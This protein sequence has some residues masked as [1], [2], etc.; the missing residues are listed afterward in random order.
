[1]MITSPQNH[2]AIP[3]DTPVTL[4]ANVRPTGQ[5]PVRVTWRTTTGTLGTGNPLTTQLTPAD[6]TVTA[7]AA[8]AVTGLT[9]QATVTIHVGPE[10][11]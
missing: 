7:I 8:D 2:Q 11:L 3:A 9:S 4:S 1:V 6:T 5:D 10:L